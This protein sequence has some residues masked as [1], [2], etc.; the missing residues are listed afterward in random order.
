MS[1]PQSKETAA[2]TA[3]NPWHEIWCKHVDVEAHDFCWTLSGYALPL[4][5]TP[6]LLM[7]GR[8]ILGQLRCPQRRF[9]RHRIFELTPTLSVDL[10]NHKFVPMKVYCDLSAEVL[11]KESLFTYGKCMEPGLDKMAMAI[12]RLDTTVQPLKFGKLG[13][14]DKMRMKVHGKIALDV[15][16]A[17]FAATKDNQCPDYLV[18]TP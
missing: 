5:S 11:G 12:D 13:W 18:K 9:I 8:V 17:I 2:V 4:M 15:K 10:S 16:H 1:N 3:T 7:K 6:C 14:W